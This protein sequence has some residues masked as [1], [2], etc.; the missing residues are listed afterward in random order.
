MSLLVKQIFSFGTCSFIHAKKGAR[1]VVESEPTKRCCKSKPTVILATSPGG[2]G[3]AGVLQ[4]AVDSAPH[5]GNEIKGSMS[6]PSFYTNFDADA[7]TLT[8]AE[9]DQELR[10]VLATLTVT[11]TNS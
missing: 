10:T 11:G 3:G 5:Y 4:A 2:R 9:L 8:N 7:G 6:I 1:G